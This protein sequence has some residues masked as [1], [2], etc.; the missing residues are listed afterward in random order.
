[1]GIVLDQ[2]GVE[3]DF[4]GDK[5]EEVVEQFQR[6]LRRKAAG[7]SQEPE[8]IGEAQPVIPTTLTLGIFSAKT[9]SNI[10]TSV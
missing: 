8:L 2:H 7:Q 6:L 1:L 4:L 3:S 5:G 10:S 9:E